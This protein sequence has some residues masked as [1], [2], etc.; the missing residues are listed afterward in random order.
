MIQ[1]D[2]V[3]KTLQVSSLINQQFSKYI[4]I[5][6]ID[7]NSYTIQSSK[8]Y[9][10]LYCNKHSKY[11]QLMQRDTLQRTFQVHQPINKQFPIYIHIQLIDAKSYTITNIPNTHTNQQIDS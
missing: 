5:Q 11:N 2:T 4:H 3:Q 6:S 7:A 10:Q 9:H 8:H 1:R